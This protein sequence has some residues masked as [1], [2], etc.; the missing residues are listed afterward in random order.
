MR[1]QI[2]FDDNWLFHKGD[3]VVSEPKR[4]GPIY[5]RREPNL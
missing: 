5:S 4:K 3:I 1:E 2:L